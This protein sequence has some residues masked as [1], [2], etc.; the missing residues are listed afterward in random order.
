MLIDPADLERSELNG[1]I[2]GLVYPRPIAWV[3][4]LDADGGRNLAPFSFFNAFCF[5]PQPVVAIGPGSRK[6]VNKDS[7]HNVKAMGEFVVNAVSEELAERAN[8]CSGEFDPDVDEWEVAGVTPAPSED[9]RPERVAESPVSLECRVR[10]VVELGSEEMQ[11][12][13]LVIGGVT[14]IHVADEAMDGLTPRPEA[15]DLV[16]RLGG[17]L[18]CTTRERFS[19]PRP[20]SRD[21]TEVRGN[22]PQRTNSTEIE[23]S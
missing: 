23:A 6:G 17:S 14:R 8:R 11:S 3:S 15:L 4:T 16:G 12:N 1:L 7:L 10:E 9:V 22:P 21:P 2:N 13:S 20:S 5:H 18:W 19:L